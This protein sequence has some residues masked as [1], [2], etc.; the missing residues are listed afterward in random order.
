MKK[1]LPLH[2]GRGPSHATRAR[3]RVSLALR[4]EALHPKGV[5][6]LLPDLITPVGQDRLILP[7]RNRAS[8]NYSGGPNAYL[9]SGDLKLQ[10]APE[11]IN[12]KSRKR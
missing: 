7:V 1:T 4:F 12:V 8:P 10:R 5:Y 2:V 6:A 9:R 11:L 3:E